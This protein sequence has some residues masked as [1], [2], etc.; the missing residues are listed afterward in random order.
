MIPG[1]MNR[2]IT[3]QE[4]G[5]DSPAFDSYGA[6]SGSWGT[7][8]T[9][10]AEKIEQKGREFF[11]GGVVGEGVVVWRIR[12][13]SGITTKMRISYDSKYYDINSIVEIGFRE[14]QELIATVQS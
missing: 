8:T 1:R 3:I 14:G 12:Y 13:D 4:F 7:Y 9:L 5:D 11:A 10:W 6:P 2:K